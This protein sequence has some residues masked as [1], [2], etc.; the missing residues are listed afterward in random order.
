MSLPYDVK[1]DALSVFDSFFEELLLLERASSFLRVPE[2]N[3][4]NRG[5]STI[6]AK[7]PAIWFP[8]DVRRYT[9]QSEN[10]RKQYKHRLQQSYIPAPYVPC[11]LETE[12]DVVAASALWLLHPVI[13]ALQ[14]CF[15]DVR[16]QAEVSSGDCR[17]DAMVSIGGRNVFVLEYKNRGYLKSSEFES[18]RRTDWSFDKE[19]EIEKAISDVGKKPGQ[20]G[21]LLGHNAAVITKQAVAYA[22]RWR[23]RHVGIFDWD[24]LF[25]WNFASM[26]MKQTPDGIVCEHGSW[27]WGTWVDRRDQYRAAL[28]GFILESHAKLTASRPDL[29]SPIPWKPLP[30]SPADIQRARME[31]DRK[32]KA[33]MSASE[34]KVDAVF[35]RRG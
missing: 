10:L 1:H 23:T 26:K 3:L 11:V 31:A 25:L 14:L 18:A 27:A 5:G 22:S 13:K 17:C 29:A 35:R 30:P 20:M 8:R 9:A 21:T 33:Q 7:A 28:L 12:S 4:A 34:Q 19:K 32:R 16:C 6:E 2:M 15:R 24:H